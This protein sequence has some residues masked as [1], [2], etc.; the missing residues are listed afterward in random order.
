MF[1]SLTTMQTHFRLI[2]FP[3]RPVPE[4]I[5]KVCSFVHSIFPGF[6]NPLRDTPLDSFLKPMMSP[7]QCYIA[8]FPLC[9]WN[10]SSLGRGSGNG[11]NTNNNALS[12]LFCITLSL[13]NLHKSKKRC[14]S[15][16]HTLGETLDITGLEIKGP[17]LSHPLAKG[18]PI[19]YNTGKEMPYNFSNISKE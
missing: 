5:V 9:A 19:F 18:C 13:P 6:P 16:Y 3:S 11:D 14:Y 15:F 2:L 7:F 17:S 10:Q 4:K 8:R 1:R 12:V